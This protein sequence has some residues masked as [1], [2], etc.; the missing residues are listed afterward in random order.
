MDFFKK[1]EAALNKIGELYVSELKNRLLRDGNIA[2]KE[3]SRS[4]TSKVVSDGVE[5]TANRY[6]STVSEGKKATSKAPSEIMVSR[7]AQWMKHKGIRPR[8]SGKMTELKYKKAAFV[9]ARSI[10]RKGFSGSK[11]I[12]R[13]FQALENNIDKEI[14]E[15]LKG[16]LQLLVEDVNKDI[17]NK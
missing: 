15:A 13:S 2:S 8:G 9:I 4:I 6:L 1:I 16:T 11:V 14:T 5:I 3:L 7:V 12:A 10:N 17:K